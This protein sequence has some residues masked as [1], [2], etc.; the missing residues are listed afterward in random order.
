M[1]NYPVLPPEVNGQ[2]A[3]L[4]SGPGSGPD[5]RSASSSDSNSFA[6]VLAA[7]PAHAATSRHQLARWLSDVAVTQPRARDIV[8][9]VNEAVTN[10]IEH[11][12]GCDASRLVA[13]RASLRD[14]T[15]TATVSDSGRWTHS[16][17]H[18]ANAAQRGHG[19]T[20][21]KRLTN[22]V[23]IVRTAK[24]TQITM[25]FDIPGQQALSR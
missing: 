19:L 9:A 1:V 23:D 6:A 2:A 22:N 10:A 15:V 18:V 14:E 24:G 4:D 13:I 8:L 5:V 21:I 12:S 7:L 16:A 3:T 11:G 17:H 20:L 25:Q